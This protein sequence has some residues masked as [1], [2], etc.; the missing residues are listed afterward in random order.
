MMFKQRRASSARGA[1][2]GFWWRSE[3]LMV[4]R[5]GTPTLLLNPTHPKNNPD[6]LRLDPGDL[7]GAVRTLWKSFPV[8]GFKVSKGKQ[9][10]EGWCIHDLNKNLTAEFKQLLLSVYYQL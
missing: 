3:E 2:V 6:L 7:K 9:T 4:S 8:V 10:P 5:A 1:F